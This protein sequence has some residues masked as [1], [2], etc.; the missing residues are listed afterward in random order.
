MQVSDLVLGLISNNTNSYCA[1]VVSHKVAYK[2]IKP[3][4]KKKNIHFY[5]YLR[6][7]FTL[8]ALI[9]HGVSVL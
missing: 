3:P 2:C 7:D 5:D 4:H 1:I 6:K 8:L 9:F